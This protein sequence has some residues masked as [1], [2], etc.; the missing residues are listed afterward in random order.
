[1]HLE[2]ALSRE[3]KGKRKRGVSLLLC[4][5]KHLLTFGDGE[6]WRPLWSQD[7]KTDAAVAVDIWVV[8][9]CGKCNLKTDEWGEPRKRG[10]RQKAEWR[11]A[12]ARFNGQEELRRPLCMK[13]YFFACS[14]AHLWRFEGVVCGEVYGQEENPA[15]V[16]TV[17]LKEREAQ[18]ASLQLWYKRKQAGGKH[19][20]RT[21]QSRA[22]VR[23]FPINLK[24]RL[25][26][27]LCEYLRVPLLWLASETL[28]QKRRNLLWNSEDMM[29]VWEVLE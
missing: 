8:D 18:W 24:Q 7:V 5:Q 6:S 22:H 3:K 29:C 2:V 1:M 19:I 26:L 21:I 9:S 20:V 28:K 16:R 14:G 25:K 13:S 23:E 12:V 15:L 4:S 27:W 10:R 11:K 17:I